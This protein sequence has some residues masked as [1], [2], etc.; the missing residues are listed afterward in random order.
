MNIREIKEAL[1]KDKVAHVAG[2]FSGKSSFERIFWN[3]AKYQLDSPNLSVLSELLDDLGFKKFLV[4]RS[5]GSSGRFEFLLEMLFC[6]IRR[7]VSVSIISSMA[8]YLLSPAFRQIEKSFFVVPIDAQGCEIFDRGFV[9]VCENNVAHLKNYFALCSSDSWQQFMRN[10]IAHTDLRKMMADG[11]TD[12][13][14]ARPDSSC[15]ENVANELISREIIGFMDLNIENNC[16][17]EFVIELFKVIAIRPDYMTFFKALKILYAYCRLYSHETLNILAQLWA[18][19]AELP[20]DSLNSFSTFLK[21]YHNRKSELTMFIWSC[22]FDKTPEKARNAMELFIS[23]AFTSVIHRTPD[24]PVIRLLIKTLSTVLAE[25]PIRDIKSSIYPVILKLLLDLRVDQHFLG[26]RA[27]FLEWIKTQTSSRAVELEVIRIL[28]FEYIYV[29][30]K[31]VSPGPPLIMDKYCDELH[32]IIVKGLDETVGSVVKR[33]KITAEMIYVT[34]LREIRRKIWADY[35]LKYEEY[36]YGFDVLLS[37]V[38]GLDMEDELFEALE[39]VEPDDFVQYQL[40]FMDVFRTNPLGVVDAIRHDYWYRITFEIAYEHICD[41]LI[42]VVG[43]IPIVSCVDLAATDGSKIALPGHVNMF[44]DMPEPAEENRNISVYIALALHEA[45][46]ILAG[47]FAIDKTYYFSRVEKPALLHFIFNCFEDYRVER[48]MREIK[49]HVQVDELLDQFNLF[50]SQSALNSESERAVSFLLHICDE[51]GETNRLIRDSEKYRDKIGNILDSKYNS[52]R[53]TS[54]HR[55]AEY[56][57]ERLRDLDVFN[58]LTTMILAREFYDIMKSWPEYTFTNSQ[59]DAPRY[60]YGAAGEGEGIQAVS[61]AGESDETSDAVNRPTPMSRDELDEM[62]RRCN[63]NPEEFI[64]NVLHMPE[65]ARYIQERNATVSEDK[66]A[67]AAGQ[68][69]QEDTAETASRNHQIWGVQNLLDSILSPSAVAFDYERAGT[70]DYSHRTEVDD[71]VATLQTNEKPQRTSFMDRLK[72][73]LSPSSTRKKRPQEKTK[74]KNKIVYSVDSHTKSRTKLSEII[75]VDVK[76]IDREFMATMNRWDFLSRTIFRLMS[77]LLRKDDDDCELSYLEGDLDMDALVEILSAPA[78]LGMQSFLETVREKRHDIEVVIGLDISG[79]T[80]FPVTGFTEDMDFINMEDTLTV[81]DVEKAFAIIFGKAMQ[82]LTPR[83]SVLAFNSWTSTTVY[84]MQTI[85]A[86]SSLISDSANRDGDFI[87]YVT[88]ILGKSPS[89]EKYF[90]LISDGCPS[91]ANYDGKS[92]LDDTIIAMRECCE[93]RIRLVYLNV[94]SSMSDYYHAFSREAS[95]S[96]Q[97]AHPE[98]MLAEISDFIKNIV[99]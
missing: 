81:L 38:Q 5:R 35:R 13:F 77:E 3:A 33:K 64:S 28:L 55:L 75:E 10:Y 15:A 87:R 99:Q 1:G 41:V 46:H 79:S 39:M 54:L 43:M 68:E 37:T 31:I 94:D 7:G 50:M 23:R 19:I 14:L 76:T 8:E 9:R 59:S 70:I 51:A 57:S 83:V 4:N 73:L 52:G 25:I 96:R 18:F 17:N 90:F 21:K 72:N 67:K 60:G 22:T 26:R 36:E 97:F 65:L 88:D 20:A 85:D 78:P 29:A 91:A 69:Y 63:E 2:I 42:P 62:Y 74:K 89:S 11:I 66:D 44:K 56:G 98:E 58:P 49:A 82:M 12:L 6:R 30:S 40:G 45:G 80:A 71:I 34:L 32:E 92:A 84:R 86:V 16:A 95:Y 27:L 61:N 53:F 47:S 48:F 24:G 93:K